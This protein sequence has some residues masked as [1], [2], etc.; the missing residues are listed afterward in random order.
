MRTYIFALLPLLPTALRPIASQPDGLQICYFAF[1][2]N[3]ATSVREGR[4]GLQPLAVSPGFVRGERLAFNM[5][6]FSPSEPAFAS[7]VP[8]ENDEC[9]GG[10]FTL[11]ASDWVKLLASEGV[12]FGGPMGYQV[13]EVSVELYSGKSVQAWTLGAG[14][15]APPTD[16]PP[17]ER[18]LELIKTGAKELELT[19]AWQRRL[20]DVQTAPFGSKAAPV[21]RD[22]ERR[23]DSTFV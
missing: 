3:L 20:A 11:T 14:L 23:P 22:F 8:S 5:V 9:H 13:R 19:G 2:A 12:P 17:S 15:L 21:A 6:G 16:L 7:I 1:G 10:V 18:Y 4:R